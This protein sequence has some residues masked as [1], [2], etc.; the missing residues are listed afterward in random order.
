MPASGCM[1]RGPPSGGSFICAAPQAPERQ[2]A[3]SSGSTPLRS[4][5]PES[6]L[7]P[8]LPRTRFVGQAGSSV[9][10]EACRLGLSVVGHHGATTIWASGISTLTRHQFRATRI[11][12]NLSASHAL[13]ITAAL[14]PSCSFWEGIRLGSGRSVLMSFQALSPSCLSSD[15]MTLLDP[16]QSRTQAAALEPLSRT[17]AELHNSGDYETGVLLYVLMTL[18]QWLFSQADPSALYWASTEPLGA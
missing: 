9:E 8:V 4:I 2:E 11:S 5:A 12:S 15:S 10:R 17:A 16:R 18:F 7:L 6:A 13:P 14:S 1:F 3:F